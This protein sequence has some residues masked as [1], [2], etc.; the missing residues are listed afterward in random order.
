MSQP[1]PYAS[2]RWLDDDEIERLDGVDVPADADEGYFLEVEL[3][4]PA[5]LHDLHADLP[6]AAGQLLY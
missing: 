3:H 4:Y 1:L 5:E 6:L 2:L